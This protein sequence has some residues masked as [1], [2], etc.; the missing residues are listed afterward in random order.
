MNKKNPTN[1][2]EILLR[3]FVLIVI[4]LAL[5]FDGKGINIV[6]DWFTKIFIGLVYSIIAGA[7]VGTFTG[8]LFKRYNKKLIGIEFNLPIMVLTFIVKIWLF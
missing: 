1:K 8:N 6:T 4:I 7:L 3:I 5:F 2:L